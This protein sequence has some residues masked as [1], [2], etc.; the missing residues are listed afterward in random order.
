MGK[1]FFALDPRWGLRRQAKEKEKATFCEQ[2]VAK[3]LL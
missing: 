2:K 1:P 3:K